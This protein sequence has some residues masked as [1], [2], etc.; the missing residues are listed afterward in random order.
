[1]SDVG[2]PGLDDDGHGDGDE[3]LLFLMNVSAKINVFESACDI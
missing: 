2:I 3:D 1:M